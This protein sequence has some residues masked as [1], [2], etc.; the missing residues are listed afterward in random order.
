VTAGVNMSP[1]S[2]EY[3]KKSINVGSL[4]P[5]IKKDITSAKRGSMITAR[6]IE[7]YPN[8]VKVMYIWNGKE[9]TD[10]MS[11]SEILVLKSGNSP[12]LEDPKGIKNMDPIPVPGVLKALKGRIV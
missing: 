8:L 7:K 1:N 5:Y 4:V 9:E 10:T 2:L 6:V 11:Y 12:D 3:L